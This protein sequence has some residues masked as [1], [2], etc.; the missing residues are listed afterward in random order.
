MT[1]ERLRGIQKKKMRVFEEKFGIKKELE[2]GIGLM[3]DLT[4][5]QKDYAMIGDLENQIAYKEMSLMK[6]GE[7]VEEQRNGLERLRYKEIKAEKL[8]E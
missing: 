2:I 6:I 7:K 1:V 8:E 4:Y 5:K 3:R